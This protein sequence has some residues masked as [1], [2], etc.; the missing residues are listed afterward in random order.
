MTARYYGT[1]HIFTSKGSSDSNIITLM[2]GANETLNIEATLNNSNITSYKTTTQLGRLQAGSEVTFQTDPISDT[3]NNGTAVDYVEYSDCSRL[4]FAAEY[5]V[6]GAEE[7]RIYVSILKGVA[8][9]WTLQDTI[10]VGAINILDSSGYNVCLDKLEGRYFGFTGANV[11]QVYIRTDETW[12]F[13]DNLQIPSDNCK[14]WGNYAV[15]GR[16]LSGFTVF[17]SDGVTG[18][19]TLK[20]FQND[21]S[22]S[23][24]LSVYDIYDTTIVWFSPDNDNI[25]IS[26]YS[27]TWSDGSNYITKYTSDT[28]PVLSMSLYEDTLAFVTAQRMYIYER[29]GGTFTLIQTFET[30]G[31]V[32]VK[33]VSDNIL[34]VRSSSTI[35]YFQGELG[36]CTYFND[37]ISPSLNLNAG[38]TALVLGQPAAL[39]GIGRVLLY[40]MSAI[41]PSEDVLTSELDVTDKISIDSI[42][43]LELQTTNISGDLSVSGMI[44]G[45][46][47]TD[48][49]IITGD[50]VQVVIKDVYVALNTIYGRNCAKFNGSVRFDGTSITVHST[51]LYFINCRVELA[52][53]ATGYR[54]LALYVDG[55]IHD[56]I[57]VDS[58]LTTTSS[59]VLSNLYFLEDGNELSLYVKHTSSGSLNLTKCL[60]NVL[61][62]GV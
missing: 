16:Q 38:A 62:I 30:T 28:G 1:R 36:W 33:V 35:Y 42:Y 11:Y 51:G 7:V 5:P 19:N 61:K 25:Y 9:V 31:L 45:S 26:E 53:S 4:V 15:G 37:S 27:G 3:F 56:T 54:E 12:A 52:S 41:T 44:R 57:K 6:V 39:S 13:Y 55:V 50:Q 29:R 40:P 2:A 34:Y 58:S 48:S 10:D 49:C 60:F 22:D 43:P 8:G 47:V 46:S 59:V 17:E 23:D 18:W 14:I 24:T 21:I 20:S 32:Q